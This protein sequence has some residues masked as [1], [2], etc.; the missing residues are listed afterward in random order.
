[1]AHS[2]YHRRVLSI[3]Q[4]TRVQIFLHVSK[5]LFHFVKRETIVRNQGK[6]EKKKTQ[7]INAISSCLRIPRSVIIPSN[8]HFSIKSIVSSP[9][10]YLIS[11]TK[12]EVGQRER[13]RSTRRRK[14]NICRTPH[15]RLIYPP[16]LT[17]PTN[18]RHQTISLTR[19]MQN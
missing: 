3:F 17:H 10:L 7:S 12:M 16:Q 13:Y 2:T 18:I 8:I 14:L 1:M 11:G 4:A 9:Y 5:T 15:H 6:K 19:P